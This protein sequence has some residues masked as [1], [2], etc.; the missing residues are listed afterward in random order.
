MAGVIFDCDGVLVDSELVSCGAWLPV[1][2]RHGVSAELGEI[3]RFIGRSDSEVL[4]HF[5]SKT[6]LPLADELV[7]ERLQEYFALASGRLQSFEGLAEVLSH[8]RRQ[9]VALAVA[10]SGRHDNVVDYALKHPAGARKP[11]AY[12]PGRCDGCG[13]RRS[14]ARPRPRRGRRRRREPRRPRAEPG[15]C[16]AGFHRSPGTVC[17]ACLCCGRCA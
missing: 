15:C 1:L 8:L 16:R 12:P 13:A 4:E 5:R 2:A 6:G 7:A 14:T 9:G 3:E 11:Y 17:G 10:S